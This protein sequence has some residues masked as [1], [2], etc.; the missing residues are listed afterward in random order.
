[1]CA[2]QP[3]TMPAF[4]RI[5]LSLEEIEDA[6]YSLEEMIIWARILDDRLKRRGPKDMPDQGLIPALANGPRRDAVIAGR[7]QYLNSV[8]GEVRHLADL[9]LHSQPLMAGTK[10]AQIVNGRIQLDFPDPVTVKIQ[11][12]A[13]LTFSN[14]RD[15]TQFA[16]DLMAAVVQLVES[17]L[18]GFEQNVPIRLQPRSA[19]PN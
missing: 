6:W 13:Q 18:A 8:A 19:L 16:N 12:R 9:N 7:S 14:K 11:D 17:I 5:G 1:M 4:H 3:P 10:S 2:I 15:G